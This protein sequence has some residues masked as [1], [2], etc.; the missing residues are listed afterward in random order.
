MSLSNAHAGSSIC[1]QPLNYQPQT[2]GTLQR[3][4]LT[5]C[6]DSAKPCNVILFGLPESS[7][8]NTKADIDDVVQHLIVDHL[9]QR[10]HSD[11][12]VAQSSSP[13]SVTAQPPGLSSLSSIILGIEGLL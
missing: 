1:S 7:L 11:W 12:V 10:M 9:V 3:L 4:A 8:P 2:A 13:Q 6:K 5:C